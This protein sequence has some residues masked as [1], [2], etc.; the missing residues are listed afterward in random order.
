MGS[1]FRAIGSILLMAIPCL[2]S[3]STTSCTP[4]RPTY[5]GYGYLIIAPQDVMQEMEDFADYK[6]AQGFLVE[7]VTLEEI[8][9]DTPGSDG[10]EKIRNYLTGYA[11]LTP[12]REFV[13]L[14]GSID[15]IPMRIAHPIYFD[16]SDS[17]QVPTDFYYE[18]LTAE[19]DADGDGF[20]GEYW[21]DMTLETEDYDAE[22]YVGRIPWDGPDQ[23]R[24]ICDTIIRYEEDRSARMRRA[25]L[26]AGTII[27]PCDT[28]FLATLG[29]ELV[30][31]TLGYETT[32]LCE[33]CPAVNPDFELT[34]AS[35]VEQWEA[36][37][38]G[39]ARHPYLQR[40]RR[41]SHESHRKAGRI[42]GTVGQTDLGGGPQ[43]SIRCEV[44]HLGFGRECDSR[45]R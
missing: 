30:F 23:I 12:E 18:E 34:E 15:A 32:R 26:G 21:D 14:V 20:F 6:T 36:V 8:L 9:A 27:E 11:T 38:P 45:W 40:W 7:K 10:P 13:L 28:S 3:L 35:F 41:I 19:W 43:V 4:P 37:Q 44:R 5:A 42:R 2:I 39:F 24:D 16:H 31:T 33:E 22:L 29:D 1:R 17:T 25:L